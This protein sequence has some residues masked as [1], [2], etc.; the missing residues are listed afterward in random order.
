LFNGKKYVT[1]GA[2]E[3]LHRLLEMLLW[4]LVELARHETELDHLQVFE[5][6]PAEEEVEGRRLQRIRHFQEKPRYER[7]VLISEEEPLSQR[8]YIID[9]GEYS[10]LLLSREY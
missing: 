9:S 4:D 3:K 5:L 2:R 8:F 10:T 6:K 7:E 1:R